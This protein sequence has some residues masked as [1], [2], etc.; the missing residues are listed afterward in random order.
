MPL[1]IELI[2]VLLAVVLVFSV[3]M[4]IINSMVLDPRGKQLGIGLLG[5]LALLLL[6][7]VA[8]QI[9]TVA[10]GGTLNWGHR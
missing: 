8:Y 3:G 9:L 5:L 10:P 4:Y 7:W 6:V 1:L 2:M